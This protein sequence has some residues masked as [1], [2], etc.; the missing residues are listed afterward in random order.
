MSELTLTAGVGRANITPPAGTRFL[1]YI[2][3]IEPATGIDTELYATA[4]VL[5]SEPTPLAPPRGQPEA[6]SRG[7]DE[8]TKVAIID[9]DLAT[10]SVGRSDEI[11]SKVAEASVSPIGA[12]ILPGGINRMIFLQMMR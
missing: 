5:A 1:G 3:R 10:F 11:R 8:Q 7:A 2:L 9:V 6:A 4:L 12:K